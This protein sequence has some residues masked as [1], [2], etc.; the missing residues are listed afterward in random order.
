MGCILPRPARLFQGE[1][2]VSGERRCATASGD[3]GEAHQG[4]GVLAREEKVK[5]TQPIYSNSSRGR[6]SRER[7]EGLSPHDEGRGLEEG[8][9]GRPKFLDTTRSVLS[10]RLKGGK[11]ASSG[12]AKSREKGGETAY[13]A[14][15]KS[16]DALRWT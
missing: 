6:E 7:R 5:K 11:E 12:D 15:R 9:V 16:D 4:R 1:A 10:C 2:G 13:G 8:G 14:E 3:S